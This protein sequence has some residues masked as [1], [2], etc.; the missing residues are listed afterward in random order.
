MSEFKLDLTLPAVEPVT[1]IGPE[2]NDVITITDEILWLYIHKQLVENKQW[3]NYKVRY[4]GEIYEFEENGQFREPDDDFFPLCCQ[5]AE[6]IIFYTPEEGKEN[7]ESLNTPSKKEKPNEENIK[8][9]IKSYDDGINFINEYFPPLTPE[10]EKLVEKENE[11]DEV[12]IPLLKKGFVN[13][14]L[15]IEFD[16]CIKEG[17]PVLDAFYKAFHISR[18]YIENIEKEFNK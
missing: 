16:N 9:K 1:I 6:D 12:V 17:L 4:K 5:F 15:I 14:K 10:E 13:K 18:S 7:R 11:S 3:M 2:G 8:E